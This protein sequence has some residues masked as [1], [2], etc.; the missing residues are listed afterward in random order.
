MMEMSLDEYEEATHFKDRKGKYTD[1]DT[2]LIE[3]EHDANGKE[4]GKSN[5][6]GGKKTS[7]LLIEESLG[8]DLSGPSNGKPVKLDEED[9]L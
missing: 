2:D 4:N 3:A 5:G 6:K 7:A 9:L 1:T 8:S